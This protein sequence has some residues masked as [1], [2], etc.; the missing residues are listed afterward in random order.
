VEDLRVTYTATA[1]DY[2]AAVNASEG[3]DGQMPPVRLALF[4]LAGLLIVCLL[5]TVFVGGVV[6]SIASAASVALVSAVVVLVWLQRMMLKQAGEASGL[7]VLSLTEHGIVL[8]TEVTSLTVK[9]SSITT[10]DDQPEHFVVKYNDDR[11]FIVVPKRAFDD[12]SHEQTFRDAIQRH[13]AL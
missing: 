10:F 3:P 13:G 9:W 2:R 1:E 5:L 12:E 7:T 8:D 11:V 4:W 6:G